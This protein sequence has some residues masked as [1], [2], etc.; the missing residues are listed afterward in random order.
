MS[1]AGKVITG[2][3][4]PYVATYSASGT[5]VTYS[6]GQK[7]ARGVAVNI[8]PEVGNDNNFYADNIAAE[9]VGGRFQGGKVTLTV[10]GLFIAAE[11]L[12]MGIPTPTSSTSSWTDYGDDMSIPYVG[13]GFIVRYMSG[14][15]E[16]FTPIVLTKTRFDVGNLDAKTQEEE[17]DWQTTELTAS[18]LRNDEANHVWKKVGNDQTTE[19]AAEALIKTLFG[20][21]GNSLEGN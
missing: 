1:E 6:N 12:I 21:T 7:L 19:A 10:D 3:G 16:Y 9:S 5:T 14:G 17:I 20:I 15:T 13:I 11:R 4:L 8:A 2:F 18:I